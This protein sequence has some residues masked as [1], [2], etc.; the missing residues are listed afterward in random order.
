LPIL[1][2]MSM[3]GFQSATGPAEA[4]GG[5][6]VGVWRSASG[7]ASEGESQADQ[8]GARSAKAAFGEYAD[9]Y[10]DFLE[11]VDG[12]GDQAVWD[13]ELSTLLARKGDRIVGV[14][15]STPGQPGEGHRQQARA[16]AVAA[17]GRL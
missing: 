12:L 13:E 2:D 9:A 7:A 16:L 3:C 8:G 15:L 11:P 6:A 4:R 17:L 5:V 10:D 14:R 1:V